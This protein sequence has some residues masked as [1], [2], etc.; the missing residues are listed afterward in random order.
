MQ[1]PER[2]IRRAAEAFSFGISEGDI[3][4]TLVN[5]GVSL[6]E[7]FLQTV[8]G[9]LFAETTNGTRWNID[10]GRYL[11]VRR[12]TRSGWARELTDPSPLSR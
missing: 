12:R 10:D 1:C 8:A 3:A 4:L 2:N 5:E 9:R 7:A 11:E 6:E